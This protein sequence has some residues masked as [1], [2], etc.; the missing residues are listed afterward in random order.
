MKPEL[1]LP[2]GNAESFNAAVEGGADAVYMGVRK[3]NARG[4]AANFTL[5]Q[6]Q[7]VLKIAGDQNKRVYL[8][9]NTVVKNEEIPELMELLSV[10][11]QTKVAALI[12]QDWGV[13][14][15]VKKFFPDIK[16][17][18]STQMQTHNSVG[19]NFA[20]KMDFG[21]V[22]LA[23]EL[24]FEELQAIK[25]HT[26]L[27]LEVFAHGALCYSF[28]GACLFSS[29]LGG[30]GANRGLCAQPC[31]RLFETGESQKFMFSLKD[32]QLIS[33]VPSLMELG[34]TSLKIEGRMRSA[35]YTYRVA[36][37]YRMAIDEPERMDEAKEI[38]TRDLGRQKTSYFMG[39][40]LQKAITD[41]PATGIFLGKIT[42]VSAEGFAF[43]APFELEEG[44][45]IRVHSPEGAVK[46]AIKLK[47]FTSNKRNFIKVDKPDSEAKKGDMVFLAEFRNDKFK[48]KLA[49]QGDKVPQALSQNEIRK[50]VSQLRHK[51]EH[52]QR[53]IF[54]RIDQVE[55]I[56]KIYI[57]SVDK[58][59]LNFPKRQWKD[60]MTGN[61]FI[62]RNKK[63]FIIELPK[64][65]AEGDVDHYR[66]FCNR[67]KVE[68]FT[69]FMVSQLSQIDLL[70]DNVTVSVNENVYS[71][72]DATIA[73]FKEKGIR[74]WVYPYEN[75]K[76]NLKLQ[77]DRD[78]I[79]PVF[80]HPD[81]FYSRMPIKLEED[82]QE[83][84]AD[85]NELV[86]RRTVR[87]GITIVTPETPVAFFQDMRE[88]KKEGYHNFLLDF[89]RIKPSQNKF[90]T[91][92]K[93]LHDG[94]QLQPS[95]SFNFSKGLK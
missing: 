83:T 34:I 91:S 70:P 30:S 32:H 24:T 71:F 50:M 69:H 62:Q 29:F 79:V 59:I 61:P 73:L 78:G 95:V 25:K 58:V 94:E 17:H 26:I 9:L 86:Y 2:A 38:L 74:H 93:H 81:L 37:A 48:N 5:E 18:A 47:D 43:N 56:K 64:F 80:F 55:W 76:Q 49:E 10:L 75:E 15:L 7:S 35:E 28:S 52:N 54:V 41:N 44:N 72:N 16:L 51:K 92:I 85:D 77:T 6:L 42:R 27:P 19:V 66:N 88:L 33:Y 14:Y 1:L 57:R 23:R 90:N 20:D 67:C 13:Y 46:E 11:A 12:I 8:T 22:I 31:R 39:G 87:D 82:N 89:S 40:S 3:F 68:G 4:R 65:I 60:F 84:F 63:K 36:Q 53:N 45:R 21:R